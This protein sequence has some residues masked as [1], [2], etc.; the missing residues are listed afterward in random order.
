MNVLAIGAHPDDLDVCC[1]GTLALLRQAGHRVVMAIV[2]DGGAHPPG[3]PAR[4]SARRQAEAQ[5]SS[6]IIGAELAWLGLPDGGLLDDLPT[7]RRFVQLMLQVSP[8][9]ILTH[10]PEDYHSDHVVASRL[11]QA[12]VQMAWAPPRGLQ[13]EPLRKPVPVAFFPPSGGINFIPDEYVDVTPVWDTKVRMIAC[14]RSQFLPGPDDDAAPLGEPL[15]QYSLVRYARVV[16]EF[17][18]LHC[19]RRYAEAFRWW[20]AA[21]RLVTQRMLP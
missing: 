2:T 12:T 8:D 14:H 10:N 15:E 9:L 21:D 19:W 18:G 11:V 16:G 4:V 20:R 1:A 5:A 13:G 6:A 7:R 17:F 3:D